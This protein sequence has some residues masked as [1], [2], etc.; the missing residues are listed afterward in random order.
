MTPAE[1]DRPQSVFI[2]GL[3]KSATG[4]ETAKVL[5]PYFRVE[6]IPEIR[7]DPELPSL[8]NV[9]VS[10]MRAHLARSPTPGEVGCA[11]AHQSAYSRLLASGDRS[12]IILENDA[13]IDSLSAFLAAASLGTSLVVGRGLVASFYAGTRVASWFPIEG[14]VE[15]VSLRFRPSYALAYVVDRAAARWLTDANTPIQNVADWPGQPQPGKFRFI[16]NAGVTPDASG[17]STVNPTMVS[18]Q[19]SPFARVRIATG[20]WWVCNQQYFDGFGGYWCTMV[21]PRLTFRLEQ[22]RRSLVS[23]T[24]WSHGCARE[25]H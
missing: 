24:R 20:L 21:R 10:A 7:W 11:L 12:A 15:A 1:G 3:S 6:E 8:Y 18:R 16:T 5:D 9:D 17:T 22:L 25:D 2:I 4:R 19:P 13:R 23:P 14:G